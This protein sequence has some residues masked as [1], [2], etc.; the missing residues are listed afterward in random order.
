[1]AAKQKLTDAIV[2]GLEPPEKGYTITRDT[3]AAGFAVRV[4]AKGVR[5]FVLDYYTRSGRDRSF[6]IGK[7]PD[8]LVTAA[9]ARAR[10]LRREIDNGG[11]PRADVEAARAAPTVSELIKRFEAEWLPRKRPITAQEYKRT[12]KN[13]IAPHFGQHT[14]VGDVVYADIDR[15]HQKITDAGTPYA[16][17]RAVAIMSKMFTLA[18]RWEMI[19][20]NP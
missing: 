14:K 2:R 13:H 3:E 15:L 9:R 1:M 11:D 20:T 16:A 5:S 4:T 10:D 19:K 12:I 17:N 7:F 18:V 6:T 8:W